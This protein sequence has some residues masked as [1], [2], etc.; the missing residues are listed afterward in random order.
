MDTGPIL[1]IISEGRADEARRAIDE[2][3]AA[4][5]SP[6]DRAAVEYLRGR[7][8]WR[9]GRKGEAISCYERAT[10]I[11]PSSDASVALDQARAIM[12]FFNKDLYN[13]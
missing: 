9:E 10:A 6:A 7:M 4:A 8:A 11:D 12:D 1:Q 3:A 13:P 2:A 5:T